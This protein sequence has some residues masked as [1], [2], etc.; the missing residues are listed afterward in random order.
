MTSLLFGITP[1]DPMTMILAPA[2]LAAVA[3]V[4]CL[5]PAFRAARI[6]PITALRA[7]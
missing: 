3:I 4:A 2:S 5:F 7:D 1:H 6:D